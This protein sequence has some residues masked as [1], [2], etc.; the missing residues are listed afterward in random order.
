MLIEHTCKRAE[1]EVAQLG[2]ERIVTF[3][4]LKRPFVILLILAL[5]VGGFGWGSADF[6]RAGLT[7]L[8]PPWG[9][10]KYPTRTTIALTSSDLVVKEGAAALLQANISGVIPKDAMTAV[11]GKTSP[12]LP[13]RESRRPTSP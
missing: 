1:T 2:G 5:V 13:H 3:S 11:N 4:G 9:S 6:L 12:S 10:V 8:L 7:R